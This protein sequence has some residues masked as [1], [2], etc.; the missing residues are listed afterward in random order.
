QSAPVLL[1]PPGI[2][3]PSGCRWLYNLPKGSI[4]E[5][6]VTPFITNVVPIVVFQAPGVTAPEA[7]WLA[8]PSVIPTTTSILSIPHLEASS[9]SNFPITVPEGTTSCNHSFFI[10]SS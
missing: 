9:L 3:Y 8:H 10:P 6:V 2:Q 4:M 5:L 1:A 7:I